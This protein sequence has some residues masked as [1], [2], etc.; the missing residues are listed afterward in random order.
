MREYDIGCLKCE[1]AFDKAHASLLERRGVR[2]PC[3]SCQ[4]LGVALYGTGTTWRGG[5]GG[6]ACTYDV[7]DQC[8]GSG[9]H[10][11]KW[12][13]LRELGRKL[14]RLAF[15]ERAHAAGPPPVSLLATQEVPVAPRK[16]T[17]D[18]VAKMLH[19][20]YVDE[21]YFI[22][23]GVGE[24]DGKPCVH[25]YVKKGARMPF[26]ANS[27]QLWTIGDVEVIVH[28]TGAVEPI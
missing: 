26:R 22:S 15:F 8:W 3:A 19:D 4:G 16:K 20:N 13:D 2:N 25:F 14:K 23:I 27:K 18:E 11:N 1:E 17:A 28:R 24:S 6:Q 5:C 7:C 10:S 12:M 21:K 9:D